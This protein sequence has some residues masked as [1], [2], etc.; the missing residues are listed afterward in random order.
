M[1]AFHYRNRELR[2][3]DVALQ[4]L[5]QQFGTPLYVY[6]ASS[7]LHRFQE[8][9][10]E[11]APVPHLICYAVKTNSN[12]GIL[13]ALRRAG[14]GFDIVSVGELQRVLAV[15]AAA[16]RIVYAGVG[17]RPE[18]I[19]AALQADIAMFNVESMPEAESLAAI[20]RNMNRIASV[21]LRINP[22]LEAGAHSY[23]STG[24][25][26][27]KFGFEQRKILDAFDHLSALSGLRPIGL[28]CHV[29]SQ[30][31]DTQSHRVV[32]ERL[33][34]LTQALRERGVQIR[35]LN[36]GG[37]MGIRY[38]DENAPRARD[39]ATAVVPLVRELGIRLIVEPG[40]FIIGNAGVLLTQ[41]LY[42]KQTSQK[43]FLIVDAGM[44]DLMRPSLYGAHHEI[45]P[46]RRQPGR[47]PVE[48]DI[49][50]PICES[51][52]F[53]ARG[54]RLPEISP[55]EYLAVCSAGA[56]GFSMSSN[57]NS[58]PR[59]AEVLVAGSHYHL[60][61]ERETH[62]DLMHLE[63]VWTHM[64]EHVLEAR[65]LSGMSSGQSRKPGNLE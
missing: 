34:E 13:D 23:L 1:I 52:D 47:D 59:A 2:C 17:K 65:R 3:E 33:V 53:L 28:H 29:G 44:N 9:S 25:A 38:S 14:S 7:I 35:V 50:G 22:D 48:M 56:Y 42:W 51:G 31:L 57:Y 32:A 18:E 24:S 4:H 64:D 19:R 62:D 6:S 12:L 60:V 30:I 39:F 27:E 40:R 16:N 5:S 26:R 45:L 36:L 11:L 10:T 37:G 54:R 43:N 21:A 49:V 41:A 8:L 15:G 20:A 55:G 46:L 58:R 63:H 61:R